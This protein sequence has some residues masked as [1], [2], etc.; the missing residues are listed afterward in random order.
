MGYLV[1]STHVPLMTGPT[2]N[3]FNDN[4]Y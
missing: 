3:I 2:I 1:L 4:G